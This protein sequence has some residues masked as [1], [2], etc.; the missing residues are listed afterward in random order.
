MVTA[1]EV[2]SGKRVLV[3]STTGVVS[4]E[5][6]VVVTS[7]TGVVS[8][9]SG[10][11]VTSVDVVWS[12]LVPAGPVA[13]TRVVSLE[14]SATVV[15]VSAG[16]VGVV[17]TSVVVSER[18]VVLIMTSSVVVAVVTLSTVLL[19]SSVNVGGVA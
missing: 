11:V 15:V 17:A 10:V 14:L 3:T 18:T 5:I 1:T 16:T 19:T 13:C 8:S 6:G 2:V 4:S 7:A 12:I 9:G